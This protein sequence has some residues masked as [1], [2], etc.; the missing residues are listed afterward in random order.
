MV[1]HWNRL[2]SEVVRQKGQKED[3]ESYRPVSLNSV[4][5]KIMEQFL[6]SALSRHVQNS[7]RIRPSCHGFM[8]GRSCLTNPTSFQDQV[9]CLVDEG[10]AVDVM[11]LD[12]SK[13][14]DS[15]SHSILLE[16][17]VAHGLYRYTLCWVKKWLDDRAQRVV[18]NGV[19]SSW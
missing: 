12:F 16:K 15:V 9:T 3:P 4:P 19:K 10:K 17:L 14:F 13:D 2:P 1:G 7:Q 5:G 8:K 6:F 11:Y 18:V